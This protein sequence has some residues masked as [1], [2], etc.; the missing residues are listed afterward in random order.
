MSDQERIAALEKAN[1]ELRERLD[2]L[3]QP[4]EAKPDSSHRLIS[5]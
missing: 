5:P 4:K 1:A 3:E 2:K